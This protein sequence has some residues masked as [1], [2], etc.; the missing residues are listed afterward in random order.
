VYRVCRE[1]GKGP[2][3]LAGW[4]PP[5]LHNSGDTAASLPTTG[6]YAKISPYIPSAALYP[7]NIISWPRRPW[8]HRRSKIDGAVLFA[9]EECR[10]LQGGPGEVPS[11]HLLAKPV[12][13]RR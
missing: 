11:F 10:G 8:T 3:E 4:V 1:I 7:N 2:D 6:V 13:A 12:P 5:P 9:R